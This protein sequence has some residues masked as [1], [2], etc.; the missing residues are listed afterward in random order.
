M[1]ILDVRTLE[2]SVH[3]QAQSRGE[4]KEKGRP[5]LMFTLIPFPDKCNNHLWDD[6]TEMGGRRCALHWTGCLIPLNGG[7]RVQM[8]WTGVRLVCSLYY[9]QKGGARI[10][11]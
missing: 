10:V 9:R 11:V 1:L 5:Y 4:K 7:T 3:Q 2:V 6:V 8:V